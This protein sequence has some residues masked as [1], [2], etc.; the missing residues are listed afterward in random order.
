M[1]T[2]NFSASAC[3]YCRYYNVEGRRGG[4]CKQLGVPVRGGWRA[5]SLALAPFAPSWENIDGLMHEQKRLLEETLSVNCPMSGAQAK[6]EVKV[7]LSSEP[8]TNEIMI[9]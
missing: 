1:N 2:S 6:A 5:C 8:L 3:R 4:M 9:A 7:S